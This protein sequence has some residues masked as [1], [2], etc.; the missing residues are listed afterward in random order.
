MIFSAMTM[1]NSCR[2]SWV[3][4]AATAGSGEHYMY[5]IACGFVLQVDHDGVGGQPELLLPLVLLR[6]LD[7]HHLLPGLS[8]VQRRALP[9][10]IRGVHDQFDCEAQASARARA[11]AV[12]AD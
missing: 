11:R 6:E 8:H 1:S 12:E 7:G 2:R 4:V 5:L 10:Q 9:G 3:H